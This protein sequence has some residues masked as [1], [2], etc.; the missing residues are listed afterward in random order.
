MY[1]G[2]QLQ[3]F[4]VRAGKSAAQTLDTSG[5]CADTPSLCDSFPCTQ[6]PHINMCTSSFAFDTYIGRESSLSS[7]VNGCYVIYPISGAWRGVVVR[8]P[9]VRIVSGGLVVFGVIGEP[10]IFVYQKSR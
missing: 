6:L 7:G 9:I 8:N 2:V 10:L 3:A 5:R 4:R 1:D